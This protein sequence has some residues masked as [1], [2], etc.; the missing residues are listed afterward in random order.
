VYGTSTHD[1]NS[2]GVKG[3]ALHGRGVNG[4]SFDGEGIRGQSNRNNGVAGITDTQD[5]SGVYGENTH[6]GFGTYGR[7]NLGGGMGVYGEAANGVG[8]VG[9]SENEI[10]VQAIS[11]NGVALQT[12]GRVSFSTTGLADV[13]VGA[14][15]VTITPGTP[16]Q[17]TTIVLRT[18]ECSQAG[19][20]IDRLTKDTTA[21]TFTVFLSKKVQSLESAR[22]AW[23]V[24]G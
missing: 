17:A 5:A 23:S 21:N 3:E 14:N 16:I 13:P 12:Q 7:S 15:Q 19:I 8:V 18:L 6:G 20:S 4:V 2:I 1:A 22:V 11:P 9:N 10:G 24:I